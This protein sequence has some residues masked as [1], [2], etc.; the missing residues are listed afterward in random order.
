[1]TDHASH[2]AH[3]TYRRRAISRLSNFVK[4]G[5]QEVA[6][7]TS[8]A[9]NH[10]V[11]A[12]GDIV[13]AQSSDC[14]YLLLDGW[15][16]GAVMLENGSRHLTMVCLPGDILGLPSL[17]VRNPID[18][19]VALTDVLVCP[20]PVE[21]IGAM[22]A[23][24]PRL[25]ALMFLVSQEERSLAIERLAMLG[26]A[27]A[28]SRLAA[29]FIRLRERHSQLDKVGPLTFL[30]PLTQR[31]IGELIGV[32]AVYVNGLLKEFRTSGLIKL[33]DRSLEIVDHRGLLDIAGI[34]PWHRSHPG[35]LPD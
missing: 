5:E 17:A 31:E 25:A 34:A 35:W 2:D 14:L 8:M 13:H 11:M 32:S 21:A 4:L 22:F 18:T 26:Q 23:S 12:K 10:C 7:L 30:M 15:A 1:M 16:A 20:I 6:Q 27:D 24:N 3:G 28:R 29:L 19:V 33:Q 9:G